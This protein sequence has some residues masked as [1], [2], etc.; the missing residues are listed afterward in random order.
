MT[1]MRFVFAGLSVGLLLAVGGCLNKGDTIIGKNEDKT[2]AE[3]DAGTSGAAGAV[4]DDDMVPDDTA[5]DDAASDDIADDDSADD[6]AASDD[7]AG[8][9]ADDD[10]AVGDD[11]T[12]GSDDDG[13]DDDTVSDDDTVADDAPPMDDDITDDDAAG[14]DDAVNDDDAVDS[15]LCERQTPVQLT[16][17]A[18]AKRGLSVASSGELH[19]ASWQGMPANVVR[20]QYVLA[21]EA[22]VPVLDTLGQVAGE[23]TGTDDTTGYVEATYSRHR[24]EFMLG[25][26][27]L[28]G[29][30]AYARAAVIGSDGA[31]VDELDLGAFVT[32]TPG[33]R[34]R[35]SWSKGNYFFGYYWCAGG[36]SGCPTT[37]VGSVRNAG[38]WLLIDD[39]TRVLAQ[40][41]DT[42]PPSPGAHNGT[43]L[44][45]AEPFDEEESGQE[46]FLGMYFAGTVGLTQYHFDGSYSGVVPL[47]GT[48]ANT[49]SKFVWDGQKALV[50]SQSEGAGA[51]AGRALRQER[52]DLV[53]NLQYEVKLTTQALDP[54]GAHFQ[55][56]T[57]S[58][59]AGNDAAL[60]FL[61]STTSGDVVLEPEVI[62][63]G[64]AIRSAT[65]VE[66]GQGFVAFYL[67]SVDGTDQVMAARIDC[68]P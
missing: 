56:D 10:D 31:V 62:A 57:V 24:E 34:H 5:D 28:S 64:E 6:D 27:N 50:F 15:R 33:G 55:G 49:G 8:D 39:E 59:L 26:V 16:S 53:G 42:G 19:L 35:I 29:A 52:W 40:A 3:H 47:T 23:V 9:D 68:T 32:F 46:G 11:D 36:G 38:S 17:N 7:I 20:V 1:T 51:T 67:A 45:Q 25:W 21:D 63:T 14:D 43:Q 58:L 61:Q 4:Q 12:A 22:L 18:S 66:D 13:A 30:T 44:L 2:K 37:E 65:L 60:Y 54:F 48:T 41:T